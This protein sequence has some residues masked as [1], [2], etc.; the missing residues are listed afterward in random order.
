MVQGGQRI[1]LLNEFIT[2]GSRL[3]S[4]GQ[5]FALPKMTFPKSDI[6][7]EN[8]QGFQ[9]GNKFVFQFSGG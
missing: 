2:P 1:Q 9:K 5:Q 6:G 4:Q 3:V 8:G 7:P